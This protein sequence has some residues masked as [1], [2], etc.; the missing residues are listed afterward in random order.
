M[1]YDRSPAAD[2]AR[3]LARDA[4]SVCRH[5][6]PNGRREGRYWLVG[7][8]A[9]NPGRSLFVRLSGSDNGKGAAGK[10]TDAA[11][12]EYGDLLDL[13]R[14]RCGLSAFRDVADEARAFLSLPRPAHPPGDHGPPSRRGKP[15]ADEDRVAAARRLFA[16]SRPVQG[17]AAE[18]YLAGRRITLLCGAGALRFH[19]A[20]YYRDG[21][22]AT[23][24][25][26]AL[27]AAVTDGSGR[28]MGVHRTWLAP[29][30]AGKA[31]VAT[32]RRA[33]GVLLGHGVRFGFEDAG[34]ADVI[35]AGEGIETMLSL[36]MALPEAPV[37]AGLSTS[38]LG[39]LLLPDGLQR[40][41]IA[42][43]SDGAGRAG[44]ERLSRRALEAGI[45]TLTL[46]PV[47][48]DFNDD[49]RR[50]G[51]EALRLHLLPQLAPGDAARFLGWS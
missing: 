11:T 47:L 22:G 48:G 12:G 36:R 35:A 49:L 25:L 24:A 15:R 10:W 38:H 16:M 27:I 42:A 2:L 31:R 34:S 33:M 8:T 5:Y 30:G 19:P 9:N 21:D 14:A 28:I 32:P 26:P 46:R 41:Y 40:L 17:T 51:P 29:G 3:R 6:L 7:D 44:T 45:E 4:E 43:D 37:I 18:A 13:I 39:A 50:S 23:H 20:C 1:T